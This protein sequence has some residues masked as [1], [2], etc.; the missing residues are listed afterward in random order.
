[1]ID[2][3]LAHLSWHR[4][5]NPPEEAGIPHWRIATTIVEIMDQFAREAEALGKPYAG[6]LRAG[7]GVAEMDLGRVALLVRSTPTTESATTS[8]TPWVWR[9]VRGQSSS[10]PKAPEVDEN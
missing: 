10:S 9:S 1:M 7:V 6:E 2:R 5:E 3:H 4:V 8:S